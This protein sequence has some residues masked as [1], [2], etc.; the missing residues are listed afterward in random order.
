MLVDKTDLRSGRDSTMGEN[1]F[2]SFFALSYNKNRPVGLTLMRMKFTLMCRSS[3]NFEIIIYI[4]FFKT[5]IFDSLSFEYVK[6]FCH[7]CL[8]SL[9]PC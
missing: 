1:D 9:M 3:L 8:S 7:V 4:F 6:V 5:V 2:H